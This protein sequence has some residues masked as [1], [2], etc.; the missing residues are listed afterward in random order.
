M[1]SFYITLGIT[2]GILFPIILTAALFGFVIVVRSL[3]IWLQEKA[4]EMKKLL[5]YDEVTI[6]QDLKNDTY[7]VDF[8]KNGTC[9]WS[10]K[11]NFKGDK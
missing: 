11:H 5:P 2:F 3:P 1:E 9:V 6:T 7:I 10:G 4:D 8:W